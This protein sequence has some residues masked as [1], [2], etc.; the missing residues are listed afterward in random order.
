MKEDAHMSVDVQRVVAMVDAIEQE[1][2]SIGAWQATPLEEEKYAFKQA[3]A[4]DTMSFLQW[5]QFIFLV[6][7]RSLIESNGPFP[8]NSQVGVQAR[9]EF[10]GQAEAYSLADLLGEFDA[11]FNAGAG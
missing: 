8:S 2:R 6:R 11:L 5:L 9:R 4:M 3:F 10:D 7:V 1:M